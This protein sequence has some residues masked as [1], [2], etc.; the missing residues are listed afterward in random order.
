M[1]QPNGD[2]LNEDNA[3]EVE[4]KLKRLNRMAYLTMK[5]KHMML[6]SYVLVKGFGICRS[7][8][9]KSRTDHKVIRSQLFDNKE[10]HKS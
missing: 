8:S 10:C 3:K 4:S 2:G 1:K 7:K 5:R 9:T 6:N